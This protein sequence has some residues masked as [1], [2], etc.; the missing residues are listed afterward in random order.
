MSI[1]GLSCAPNGWKTWQSSIFPHAGMPLESGLP[2]RYFF[3]SMEW[4][5]N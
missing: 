3:K 5:I 2:V 4:I 1:T